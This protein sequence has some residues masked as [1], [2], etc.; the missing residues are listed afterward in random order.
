MSKGEANAHANT[1]TLRYQVNPQRGFETGHFT[2]GWLVDNHNPSP[3]VSNAL[4]HSGTFAAF[5]GGS[6]PLQFCGFGNEP[7]GDSS[8]YQEF[9]P[10]PANA[11]LSFWHWDCTTDSIDFDWQDA[12]ITDPNG[13]ILQ[14]IFHQCGNCQSWVNQTVDLSSYVGQTIRVKF[15]VHQDGFGALTGMFVDDVRLTL[16]CGSPTPAP[17][18]T[19]VPRSRPTPRSRPWPS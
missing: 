19:P 15:L 9:G 8:F 16:P 3:I 17:R 10:V 1:A 2:R 5:L 4:A 6:L 14:T 13:N 11:I 7:F 12:Y 18:A